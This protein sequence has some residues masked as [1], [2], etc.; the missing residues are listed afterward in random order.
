M[1]KATKLAKR[2]AVIAI[3]LAVEFDDPKQTVLMTKSVRDALAANKDASA[4]RKRRRTAAKRP[5]ARLA[6]LNG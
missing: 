5:Q 2:E 4:L 6:A 3:I 1:T